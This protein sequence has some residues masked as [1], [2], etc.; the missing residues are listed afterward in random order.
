[1][2]DIQGVVVAAAEEGIVQVEQVV[3]DGGVVGSGLDDQTQRGDL[4]TRVLG[5]V[6]ARGLPAVACRTVRHVHR[7]HGLGVVGKD[8]AK[9]QLGIIA[10]ELVVG[11][12]NLGAGSDI[13]VG[14]VQANGVV[15]GE[16]AAQHQRI[17]AFVTTDLGVLEAWYRL[18]VL[19]VVEV[20]LQ[21]VGVGIDPPLPCRQNIL[22]VDVAPLLVAGP[23]A[24]ITPFE[25]VTGVERR[26]EHGTANH[27]AFGDLGSEALPTVIAR[28][29]VD[30]IV[31]DVGGALLA[32]G[33]A[34]PQS[35]FA[36]E[37]LVLVFRI[38]LLVVAQ[39]AG[40]EVGAERGKA[41][42]RLTC[43][44]EIDVHIARIAAD[45]V[46]LLLSGLDASK[47]RIFRIDAETLGVSGRILKHVAA[48]PVVQED[49]IRDLALVRILH[50]RRIAAV[51]HV[52]VAYAAT[53]VCG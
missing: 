27:G 50:I 47:H 4:L 3:L 32:G 30:V 31:G 36:V 24:A 5:Q 38:D 44:V 48:E 15:V 28:A 23:F 37:H 34:G 11:Q 10:V 12:V 8:E 33:R 1:M 19:T 17:A 45:T 40:D 16:L 18:V 46:E 39:F 13:Q 14:L 26:R 52:L 29:V 7:H 21:R 6:H 9:L 49:G 35:A 53:R 41:H 51:E 25:T 43:I 22:Q 42:I 2:L 20:G